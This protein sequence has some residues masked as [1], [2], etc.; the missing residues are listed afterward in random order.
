MMGKSPENHRKS[1]LSIHVGTSPIKLALKQVDLWYKDSTLMKTV[2]FLEHGIV[3]QYKVAFFHVLFM[4]L[5][6]ITLY[7]DEA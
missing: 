4:F 1:V 7:Y 5:L 3:F 6:S 2:K